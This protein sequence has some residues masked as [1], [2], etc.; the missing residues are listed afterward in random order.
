VGASPSTLGCLVR[1]GT[2]AL[3]GLLAVLGDFRHPQTKLNSRLLVQKNQSNNRFVPAR[4]S[5]SKTARGP[6]GARPLNGSFH[7]ILPFML[8]APELGCN[9]IPTAPLVDCCAI[10]LSLTASV[11]HS[12]RVLAPAPR[13][14]FFSLSGGDPN[15]VHSHTSSSTLVIRFAENVGTPTSPAVLSLCVSEFL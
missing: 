14:K 10:H 9:V 3:T 5:K 7:W 4:L 13:A 15:A 6:T 2:M 8:E 12:R 1:L 11:A